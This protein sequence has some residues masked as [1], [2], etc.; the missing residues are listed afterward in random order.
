MPKLVFLLTL[1]ILVNAPRGRSQSSMI[2][3]TQ[4]VE[5]NRIVLAENITSKIG[6]AYLPAKASLTRAYDTLHFSDGAIHKG[7]IPEKAVTKKAVL[8]FSVVNNTDTAHSAWFFPGLYY[9]DIQLYRL[10]DGTPEP[11]QSALPTVE[12]E[13]SYRLITL[14]PHD[15]ATILAELTFVRTHLNRIR[16]ALIAPGFLASYIKDL[17]STN[18]ESKIFTYLFCGV[19]AMM[20]LFSLAS[21]FQGG[22]KEFL[23]YSCYAFFVG[24][25]LFIKAVYSYRTSW[26]SFFQETYLDFVMQCA[27]I[28]FYMLFMQHFLGTRRHHP[29]LHKLYNV[30]IGILLLSIAG[31]TY[32]HYFT[33]NFSLESLIENGTKILLLLMIVIF[34]VYSTRAW[35]DRLLRYLFWGNLFLLVFSMLSLLVQNISLAGTNL[36]VILKSSLSYYEIGLMLELIFFLLGLNHKNRRRLVEQA[37]ERERLKAKDQMNEYE[38]EI[39]I[40]KAQQQE[41]ERI[42]ADMHDELGSGMTA[43]RLMSEIA[44]KKMKESTPVEIEKISHSAD[45]VL[46]KMNAIIWSMNSGNDTIDNLV[47]YIRSYAIEYF[48]NT[49]ILCRISTPEHI[50]PTE[51]TGDK[52]RN[53]FL[54]VKETLNNVLKHS[55]ATELNINF[56]IDDRLVI[57]IRDNGIGIDLQ[58][59]RQFGNGLKNI[60]RRMESIGGSYQIDNTGGTTT[61]LTLS[62]V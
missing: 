49:P 36:P 43:I 4:T 8:R 45:E 60:A 32:A 39:A 56:H 9:W 38:K 5:I 29:F 21:F 41:R 11:I 40:Y 35:S 16:P 6:F 48:E 59:I 62:L 55:R 12:K 17:N 26:F 42:S 3:D 54:S 44:R 31:Y 58:K 27:G 14:A 28:L 33:E 30:G 37:R 19:L 61:T 7:F 50:E 25:M 34:L 10:K 52:R 46:N 22:N 1:M 18:M 20:I 2:P 23:Y 13:I 47:S 57:T 24:S 15:S 51:L 53:L